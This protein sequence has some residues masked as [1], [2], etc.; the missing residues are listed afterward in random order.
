MYPVDAGLLRCSK[1]RED[2]CWC[3]VR[4]KESIVRENV[5]G[6][7]LAA[8]RTHPEF[9]QRLHKAIG[10]QIGHADRKRDQVRRNLEVRRDE[11]AKRIT[12]LL[13]SLEGGQSNSKAVLT[14]I[15]ELEI[16]KTKLEEQ[17]SEHELSMLVTSPS[18]TVDETREGLPEA[19]KGLAKSSFEF[20][21]LIRQLIPVFIIYPVQALNCSQVR[22]RAR[23]MISWSSL[24]SPDQ[25]E[26]LNL[27]NGDGEWVTVDLFKQPQ[28]VQDA[29]DLRAAGDD[30]DL[31]SPVPKQLG[32][33]R[34][35]ALRARTYLAAMK[36]AGLTD[37]YM[38]LKEKP[39]NASRWRKGNRKR[40]AEGL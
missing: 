38:E 7:I 14:R 11:I 19:V 24:A 4:P 27:S 10:E 22:A 1:A 28:H 20:S 34:E 16:E 21:A 17:I 6:T 35:R 39:A 29:L 15:E 2:Q 13:E 31:R 12:N 37:P 40:E 30:G 5:I 23:F 3:R 33:S 25:A 26:N 18:I 8:A 32:M 9:E 36:N